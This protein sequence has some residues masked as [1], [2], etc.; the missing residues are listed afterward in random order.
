[1]RS[2][3]VRGR[4]GRAVR[5]KSRRRGEEG[6]QGGWAADMT[7]HRFRERPKEGQRE[8]EREIVLSK[9]QNFTATRTLQLGDNVCCW[10]SI[11]GQVILSS[12]QGKKEKDR[13]KERGRNR[14]KV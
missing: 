3:E 13:Q 5:K 8:R 9:R 14:N 1:M 11:N 10:S 4:T 12:S 7:C 2:Y 6:E